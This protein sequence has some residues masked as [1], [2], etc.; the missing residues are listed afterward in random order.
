MHGSS[1]VPTHEAYIAALEEPRRSE[2][3]TLHE[4]IRSAVPQLE[5]TMAFGILGYGTYH[6]RYASGREGDSTVVGLASNKRYI[7]LYVAGEVD[8]RPLAEAFAPRLPKASIAK[9]SLKERRT[10]RE[11]VLERGH[12]DSGKLTLQ[13]LDAALDVLA[14]TGAT[15]RR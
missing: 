3:R 5:P 15:K 1:T 2:I 11:V 7:S 13:Q 4:L 14:M 6:Y 12:V 10:I 8:G 9:Q